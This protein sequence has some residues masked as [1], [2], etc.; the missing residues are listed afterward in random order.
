M[1]GRPDQ[2]GLGLSDNKITFPASVGGGS[3]KT[4]DT[5]TVK[6]KKVKGVLRL[7]S[8]PPQANAKVKPKVRATADA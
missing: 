6:G 8:W 2:E 3:I 7:F 4:G 5:C 1:G